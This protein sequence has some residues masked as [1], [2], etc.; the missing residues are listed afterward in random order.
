[1]IQKQNIKCLVCSYANNIETKYYNPL[2]LLLPA[3]GEEI[4]LVGGRKGNIE[5]FRI[6]LTHKKL[7]SNV[8][9]HQGPLIPYEEDDYPCHCSSRT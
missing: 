8:T 5:L 1:M 4:L 3:Y 6:I 2:C 9:K 7:K